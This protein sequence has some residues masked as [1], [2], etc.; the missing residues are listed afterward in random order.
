M[1]TTIIGCLALLLC[2]AAGWAE[3]P[4][5]VTEQD[6][7]N[8]S[9]GYQIGSDFKRQGVGLSPEL[10]VRGIQDALGTGQPLLT[11]EEM[12][13]TLV[14]LKKKIDSSQAEEKKLRREKY[15][16]EAEKF[17]AE[18]GRKEG[19]VTLPSGLQYRVITP[20]SGRKP[21]LADSVT[22]QYRG[23]LVSG[24]EFD[25]SYRAKK[26]NTFPLAKLIPGLQEALQLMAEGA[27]WQV[28][29][30]PRLAFDE[31]GPLADRV[32]IYE[33]QLDAVQPPK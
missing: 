27:K 30:P 15:R 31:R 6:K 12:H 2:T 17:L 1:R 18:N 11:N 25:S 14:E 16:A 32:V 10:L 26:P 20:G 3:Q 22:I 23:T 29:I 28:V 4:K 21:I 5:P 13:T 19:V 9:V 24:A 7:I 8:Y 33:L